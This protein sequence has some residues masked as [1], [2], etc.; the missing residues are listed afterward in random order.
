M[1]IYKH[2]KGIEKG[3]RYKN[4]LI[5]WRKQNVIKK[6]ERPTRLDRAHSLGYKAKQGYVLARIRIKK[7]GRRS[8]G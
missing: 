7:G 4:K 1:G 2:L 8:T 5:Q 6:I 3:N